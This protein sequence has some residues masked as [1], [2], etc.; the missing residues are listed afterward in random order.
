MPIFSNTRRAFLQGALGGPPLLAQPGGSG[1]TRD[2]AAARF[3]GLAYRNYPRCLPDYL[4]ALAVAAR[5]KREAALARI[6]S[7]QAVRERQAWVKRTLLGLIGELPEKTGLNAR[8][9]GS[10]ERPGYRLE[11]IVY[12]SR[13][14]FY[15]SANLYVP[16][17]NRPPFPGVLFQL[18]HSGNG[19]AWTSYQRA[20]QGLVRLGFLVLAFDPMGQGERIYYPDG[21][22]VRT[23][24]PGGP[25]EEHTL[26]GMQMLL[27]GT[28]CSQFQ[29][30]DAIRSL[31]Y[32]AAH[33]LVDASKL[34]STGQSGGAHLPCCWPRLMNA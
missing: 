12:E 4:R 32:L 1:K 13:P 25:D 22:G 9:A 10:L 16:T 15:V 3:P 23:R 19:K 6:V 5:E 26:P 28:T 2:A 11:R 7:V 30:W 29:L 21:T 34:A 20:C 18:G 17:S 27:A 14:K 31:D 8:V 24:L 33:P